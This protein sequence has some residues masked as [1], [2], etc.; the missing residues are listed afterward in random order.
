MGL[1]RSAKYLLCHLPSLLA[2]DELL[3]LAGKGLSAGGR[4]TLECPEEKQ[5]TKG[6]LVFFVKGAG[7]LEQGPRLYRSCFLLVSQQDVQ[8]KGVACLGA[9]KGR[10]GKCAK[11]PFLKLVLEKELSSR[12]R[13]RCIEKPQETEKTRL[14]KRWPGPKES[15][16]SKVTTTGRYLRCTYSVLGPMPGALW[17]YLT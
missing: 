16:W 15:F 13:G 12:G 11:Y 7:E 5:R 17:Q 2:L 4:D 10:E 14:Q 1:L 9:P 3:A 6:Q 8:Q